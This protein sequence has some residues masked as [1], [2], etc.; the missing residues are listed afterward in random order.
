MGNNSKSSVVSKYAR[1]VAG[2]RF[3]RYQIEIHIF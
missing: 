1:E 3:G 2:G